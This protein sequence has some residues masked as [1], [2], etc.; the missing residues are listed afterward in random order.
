MR[1]KPF[2]SSETKKI[3]ASE[4]EEPKMF[5]LFSSYTN[6]VSHNSVAGTKISDIHNV[7]EKDLFWLSVS[8]LSVTGFGA[9]KYGGETWWGNL[10]TSQ[11]QETEGRKGSKAREERAQPLWEV[12]PGSLPCEQHQG[13]P[14]LLWALQSSSWPSTFTSMALWSLGTPSPVWSFCRN[15]V[16]W[17]ATLGKLLRFSYT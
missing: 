9:G 5:S 1:F 10:L 13:W 16:N 17:T 7:K 6:W 11:H 2:R 3:H 15:S 8:K 14:N 4:Y 12:V